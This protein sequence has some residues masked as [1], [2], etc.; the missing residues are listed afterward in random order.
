MGL[1]R[2]SAVFCIRIVGV[3]NGR[4]RLG[5]EMRSR[6]ARRAGLARNR[7]GA[8]ADTEHALAVRAGVTEVLLDGG[9]TAHNMVGCWTVG[10]WFSLVRK[11]LL[12]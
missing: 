2:G 1:Q 5:V 7:D 12:G 6:C 8:A 3:A 10:Q 9:G 4:G 11:S